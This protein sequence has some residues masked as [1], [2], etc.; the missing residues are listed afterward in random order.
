MSLPTLLYV[1][2]DRENLPT[3]KRTLRG[4][5]ELETFESPAEALACVQT[6]FFP[7]LIADQRMPKMTGVEFLKKTKE[8][9]PDSIGIVLT[10]YSDIDALIDGINAGVIYRYVTKP[11]KE[12]VLFQAIEQSLERV[13]L[14]Q[15]N[16]NLV[17]EL[18]RK[19]Q[20]LQE[21]IDEQF[22]FEALGGAATGLKPVVDLIG[23]V[24]KTTSTVLIR[25][26]SGVGKELVARAIHQA[27]PRK[28]K[29]FV[30]VNCGA[31]S[32]NLLES[33]LFGHEKGAFTGAAQKRIGRFEAAEG[34]TVFLDEIGDVSPKMQ[35]SLLR[36]IQERE[37][38]RVG[39]N[40]TIACDVRVLA[41]THQNLE[42]L[43]REKKFR[44]DLYYRLNVFPLQVP[45]LRDRLQDLPDLVERLMKKAARN[46]GISPLC[47]TSE[48]L[49]KLKGYDWPGNVRELENVLERALILATDQEISAEDLVMGPGLDEQTPRASAQEMTKEL[50]EKTLQDVEGNKVEAA[51]RLGLKRPTLYYHLK[52]FGLS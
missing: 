37:F 35:V 29:P 36:V 45:P 46:T 24:A 33:E 10:A 20:V 15:E 5:F 8:F 28:N 38:E 14:V 50:L 31:L 49:A 40:Q 7:V 16:R 12:A 25:G 1:D 48:A 34:G 30:R 3:L 22:D 52:R 17:E 51:K 19:N 39:G 41:A 43:S 47:L 44:E 42:V 32:E 11:W 13:R 6:S 27:S 18:K 23:K 4:K 26:E 2:D 21:E 9:S